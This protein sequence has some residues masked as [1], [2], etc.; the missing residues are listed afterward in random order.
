MVNKAL[1][2][3]IH[4]GEPERYRIS[5][6]PFDCNCV[7]ALKNFQPIGMLL[8]SGAS[9]GRTA[10][11]PKTGSATWRRETSLPSVAAISQVLIKMRLVVD[12]SGARVRGC[13]IDLVPIDTFGG[14]VFPGRTDSENLAVCVERN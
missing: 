1:V 9:P 3:L 14:T 12:V 2:L 5:A 6:S 8:R 7:H 11:C 4:G 10:S 13:L